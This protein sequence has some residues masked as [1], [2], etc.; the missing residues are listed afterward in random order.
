VVPVAFDDAVA[1]AKWAGKRLPTEA[2]WEFA[3]G[4]GLTGKLYVWG[5]ELQP[6]GESMANTWQGLFPVHD[7]GEDGF[8]GLASVAQFPANGYG[9]SD[10][11]GNAWQWCA[12]GYRPDY[13]QK[14]AD[15][16]SITKN[17]QGSE[18]SFDPLE[19][20]THKR[21]QRGGSFLCTVEYC[22]RYLV[23]S[24][25]KGEPSGA[26]DHL[27]FRCVESPR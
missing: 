27:R 2:E 17:P 22:S 1:Y 24:R 3:A 13:Y 9:L 5:D 12:D 23:G 15:Q 21:I 26:A 20:G 7:T 16:G 11:S 10:M 18:T 19:P 25:G 4:G 6:N 8:A 14:L